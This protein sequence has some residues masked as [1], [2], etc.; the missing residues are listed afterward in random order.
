[1]Y[2]ISQQLALL[3]L[4]VIDVVNLSNVVEVELSWEFTTSLRN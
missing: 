4:F 2:V 3:I 1:M